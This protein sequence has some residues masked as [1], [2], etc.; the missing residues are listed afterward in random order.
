QPT[1][2]SAALDFVEDLRSRPEVHVFA[3]GAD[4][5]KIFVDLCRRSDARLAQGRPSN[6][7]EKL[8]LIKDVA[9]VVSL[10]LGN[11]AAQAL[12]TYI[13]K[14]TWKKI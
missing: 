4:H 5:W 14:E 2:L 9:K 12:G 11:N 3:P 7:K 13:D 6:E 10:K 1:P 8:S